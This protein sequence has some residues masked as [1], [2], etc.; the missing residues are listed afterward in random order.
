MN[1]AA[2]S[3]S[4]HKSLHYKLASDVNCMVRVTLEFLV[5]LRFMVQ[6]VYR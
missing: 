4:A 2:D 6:A 5:H 3:L 1:P